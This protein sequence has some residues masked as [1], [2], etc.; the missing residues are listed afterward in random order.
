MWRSICELA[1]RARRWRGKAVSIQVGILDILKS[2]S[3]NHIREKMCFT[4]F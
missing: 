3:V 4:R 2:G 1:E